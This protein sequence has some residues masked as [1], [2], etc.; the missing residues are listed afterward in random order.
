[1]LGAQWQVQLMYCWMKLNYN[2]GLLIPFCTNLTAVNLIKLNSL[3]E[4]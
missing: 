1:M 3:Y 2:L 4:I